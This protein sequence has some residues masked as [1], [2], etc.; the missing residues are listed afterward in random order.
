MLRLE[1]QAT[2][3]EI[4]LSQTPVYGEIQMLK[5][6]IDALNED[7]LPNKRDLCKLKENHPE[8]PNEFARVAKCLEGGLYVLM[9]HE[10]SSHAGRTTK[11]LKFKV[12]FERVIVQLPPV[13]DVGQG[14]VMD[15][16]EK[17]TAERGKL[18]AIIKCGEYDKV[19]K[20]ANHQKNENHQN[21][22]I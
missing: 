14:P 7:A 15:R 1:D 4:M 20:N 22:I 19:R 18:C 16:L 5:S 2:Q 11:P 21:L 12:D 17:L 6:V 3:T 13:S 10:K 9:I 8:F